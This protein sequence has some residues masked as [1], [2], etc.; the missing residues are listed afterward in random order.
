MAENKKTNDEN[1]YLD[2]STVQERLTDIEKKVNITL[3]LMVIL[4]IIGIALIFGVFGEE[5]KKSYTSDNTNT[6]DSGESVDSASYSTDDFKEILASE[7]SSESKNETIVIMIGRQGCGYCAAYAP[8]IAEVAKDFNITVRY[9]DLAKIIDFSAY[10]YTIISD[11]TSYNTIAS[12]SGSGEWKDFAEEGLSGTPLTL[13][14]KNNKVVGGIQGSAYAE[15]VE[16]AFTNAG[17]SK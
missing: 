8:V 6:Q 5:S 9:I 16:E 7:I 10:P 15:D 14:V 11:S 4:I 2:D 3:V 1:E 12:L 13:I 17:L